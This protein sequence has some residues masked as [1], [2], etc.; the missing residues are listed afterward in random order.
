V[1]AGGRRY[2]GYTELSLDE[3][4]VSADTVDGL[5][6]AGLPEDVVKFCMAF[7][8]FHELK[9]F[10]DLARLGDVLEL[11]EYRDRYT[12]DPVFRREVEDEANRFALE[13]AS[14]VAERKGWRVPEE[15]RDPREVRWLIER[16]LFW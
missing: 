10:K 12:E 3:I 15:L 14:R 2:A 6:R 13:V 1:S 5:F 16:A 8:I 11:I 7:V 4:V 9:H